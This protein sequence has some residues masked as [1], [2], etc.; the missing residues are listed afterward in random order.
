[1]ELA[2]HLSVGIELHTNVVIKILKQEK[3]AQN[4]TLDVLVHLRRG[5]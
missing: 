4:I 3:V 1:M 5:C 2:G